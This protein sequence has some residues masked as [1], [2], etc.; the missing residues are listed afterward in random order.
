MELGKALASR[1][2]QVT[3]ILLI[4]GISLLAWSM[5]AAANAG[6]ERIIAQLGP[7]ADESSWNLLLGVTAQIT[8]AGAL[9]AFGVAT[10][11]VI[12]RE[13]SEGTISGLFALPVPLATIA[14][15]KL[16]VYQLWASFIAL[17]LTA[18]LFVTGLWFDLGP[19]DSYVLHE[20]A[21]QTIL[22]FLTGLL[23]IPAA[24]ASTVG[25]GPLAG[26]AVTLMLVVSAQ[27]TAIAYPLLA[28][29]LP[30]SA[31]ALWALQPEL[32][33]PGQLVTVLVIPLTFGLLTASAWK[34]LQ[35]T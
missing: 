30:F 22:T 24:W 31:P 19:V 23:A 6:N 12:G 34:R 33:H 27:V 1:T 26:I 20:L 10:S 11:W 9:I 25:R 16:L 15:A 29:W 18:T 32:V 4:G 13:F 7:L 2:L 5:V 3:T 17:A 28:P 35:L 8:A 21:R 14:M